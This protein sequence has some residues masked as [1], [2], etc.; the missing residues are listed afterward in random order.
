MAAKLPTPLSIGTSVSLSSGGPAPSSGQFNVTRIWAGA[1]PVIESPNLTLAQALAM[2]KAPSQLAWYGVEVNMEVVGPGL[3][4][5][6]GAT[7]PGEAELFLVVNGHDPDLRPDTHSLIT[8]LPF[9][10]GV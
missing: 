3:L 6:G 9:A 1:A 4:G 8:E 2:V 10:V 5:R 7:G